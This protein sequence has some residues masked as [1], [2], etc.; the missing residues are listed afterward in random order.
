[1]RANAKLAFGGATLIVGVEFALLYALAKSI[2][3]HA[4]FW[5]RLPDNVGDFNYV[6]LG[7]STAQGIGTLRPTSGYVWR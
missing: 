3:G 2:K 4:L 1:M 6:A 7:D 5:S